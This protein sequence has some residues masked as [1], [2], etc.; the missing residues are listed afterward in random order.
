MLILSFTAQSVFAAA[1]PGDRVI[2]LGADLNIN[3]KTAILT[4]FQ[5]TDKD[6]IVVV[7]AADEVKYLPGSSLSG[8]EY[9]S[10]LITIKDKGQGI[11]VSKSDKITQVSTEMYQNAIL[12]AGIQ[13]ADVYVT[14]PKPVTGTAALTGI[15]KAFET[16]TGKT[17]SEDRKKT[18]GEEI[19][20]TSE[21]GQNLGDQQKA[22]DFVQRLKEEVQKRN[23]QTDADYRNIIE[24][25]MKEMGIQ[26]SPD[27]IQGLIDLLKKVKSLNIDWAGLGNQLQDAGRKI[28]QFVH[29][30]PEKANGILDFF[31]QILTSL[32]NLLSKLFG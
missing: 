12:T 24:Q 18:A 8:K 5:Q 25:V 3:E 20:K 2:T 21:I 27:Q 1:N 29:D 6:K 32:Q 10:S 26:L 17:L 7:T 23:P 31:K 22:S 9:S 30:N 11:K 13:D 15:F 19:V 28:G 14:A 4:E 16:A